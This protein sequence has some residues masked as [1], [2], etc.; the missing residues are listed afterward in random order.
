MLSGSLC[1][2]DLRAAG[3]QIAAVA[4][5][6]A[7]QRTSRHYEC[8]GKWVR[9]VIMVIVCCIGFYIAAASLFIAWIGTKSW[10][11]ASQSPIDAPS[12]VALLGLAGVSTIVPLALWRWLLPGSMNNATL[13]VTLICIVSGLVVTALLLGLR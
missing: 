13:T 10:G 5:R 9:V 4:T 8:M 7:H 1:R 11:G 12:A 6:L 2:R 3:S